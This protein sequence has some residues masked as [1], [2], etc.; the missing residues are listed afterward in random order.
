[1][2]ER[3]DQIPHASSV[4]FSVLDGKYGFKDIIHY[5]DGSC[6]FTREYVFR[7]VKAKI[8]NNL[9]FLEFKSDTKWLKTII[10][11]FFLPFVV[12]IAVLIGGI[13]T[14]AD[15]LYEVK[16]LT[17]GKR[18]A[19]L[20][21]WIWDGMYWVCA[22]IFILLIILGIGEFLFLLFFQGESLSKQLA[23]PANET[24]PFSKFMNNTVSTK[25]VSIIMD[26]R[27]ANRSTALII[28]RC[29][30]GL[31]G[32]QIF[33]GKELSIYACD[34]EGCLTAKIESNKQRTLSYED[35]LNEAKQGIYFHIQKGVP[36][37]EF[38]MDRSE[39]FLDESILGNCSITVNRGGWYGYENK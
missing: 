11:F 26:I 20:P 18:K 29:G 24:V 27:G 30:T 13:N 37:N 10:S 5:S 39:I 14:R 6:S 31:A 35:T 36:S 9:Q 12:V 32:S 25:K 23:K 17:E 8:D 16:C 34:E 15:L 2:K 33:I 1:M 38:Y 21:S 4:K 19:G 22:S 28:F 7:R 3:S